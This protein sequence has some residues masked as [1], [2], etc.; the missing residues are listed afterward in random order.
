MRTR[1]EDITH[2]LGAIDLQ[3][4]DNTDDVDLFAWTSQVVERRDALADQ[5]QD[6]KDKVQRAERTIE[7]LEQQ[8]QDLVTAKEDHE[9][10]LLTKFIALLNEKKLRIRTQQRQIAEHD[11]VVKGNDPKQ[12]AR[13]PRKRRL[14]G[15]Q[16]TG[17][18]E[19]DESEGFEYMQ[20]EPPVDGETDVEPLQTSSDESEKQE[21]AEP[22][23]RQKQKTGA[24]VKVHQ[25]SCTTPPPRALPFTI[26]RGLSG[27]APHQE[28]SNK[29]MVDDEETASEGDDEL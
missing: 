11:E 28:R 14:L 6:G 16:T 27:V 24:S 3:H 26:G 5:L 15:K 8:L 22:L 25:G 21:V 10:Q 18:T 1:V 19:S 12:D 17:T 20:A 29:V 7:S 13:N 9:T 23:S 2:R 4:S